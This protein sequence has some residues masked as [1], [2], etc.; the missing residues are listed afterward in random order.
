M[1]SEI[2][3][4]VFGSFTES[5]GMR[6]TGRLYPGRNPNC[7]MHSSEDEKFG[8]YTEMDKMKLTQKYG[9]H[10]ADPQG[11]AHV[12]DCEKGKS[13]VCKCYILQC[14]KCNRYFSN[15]CGDI[16]SED[17]VPSAI[18][19]WDDDEKKFYLFRSKLLKPFDDE[20]F[21]DTVERKHSKETF[22]ECFKRKITEKYGDILDNVPADPKVLNSMI[23]NLM[24]PVKHS[25]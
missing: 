25:E 3:Q 15:Q 5:D 14:T 23:N 18:H 22:R 24:D 2:A 13:D 1:S 20:K 16:G 6:F 17:S 10:E 4:K 9:T 21:V 7:P 8:K 11:T 12:F 19:R